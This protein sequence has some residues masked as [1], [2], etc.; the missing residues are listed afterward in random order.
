MASV[1]EKLTEAIQLGKAEQVRAILEEAD[2][3]SLRSATGESPLHDAVRLGAKPAVFKLLLETT[4]ISA[5][6]INGHT[7]TDLVFSDEQLDPDYET[8]VVNHTKAWILQGRVKELEKLLLSGWLFWPVTVEQAKNVSTELADFISRIPEFQEKVGQLHK[9]IQDENI[10]EVQQILDRKKYILAADRTGLPPFHKA[11]LHGNGEMVEWFCEEFKFAIEHKDSMGRTVLHYA[12]GLPDAGYIYSM[13][14]NAGANEDA[15][16]LA[17][18]TPRDYYDNTELLAVMKIRQ[19]I[20]EILTTTIPEP[21][22]AVSGSHQMYIS[23]GLK[24]KRVP[25]PTTV[26]GRYVAEHLGTALTLALAEIAECRP[27]DPIEYLGQWLYKYRENR[28]HIDQQEKLMAE[29]REEEKQKAVEEKE[30][31]KIKEEQVAIMEA[32]RRERE[33]AEEERRR[34]EKEELQRQAR[35]M[36]ALAQR[37]NLDTVTEESE[38]ETSGKDKQGQS[39]LHKLAAQEGADL[40]ALLNLGYNLAERDITCKTPRDIAVEKGIQDNIDAIDNYLRGLIEKEKFS[41]LEQLLLDGYTEFQPVI[42]KL[43]SEGQTEEIKNFL[44]SI[45]EVQ[46]KIS[47]MLLAA[48]QGSLSAVQEQ[49]DKKLSIVKD[50]KGQSPLHKAVMM[51]H[52]EV[53]EHI[54]TAY[55]DT[56]KCKDQL[57]RTPYHYAMGLS[58]S[59]IQT[60]LLSKGADENAKDV[61]QRVPSYY[62]ENPADILALPNESSASTSDPVN[63]SEQARTEGGEDKE[64]EHA[65]TTQEEKKE[66]DNGTEQTVEQTAEQKDITE[67]P[68]TTT[69]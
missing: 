38:E 25:P 68:V 26:D 16:D 45:P 51:Q 7:V 20:E 18:R 56:L 47:S 33:K 60:L 24:T 1:R 69:S 5:R 54:V 8:M 22:L 43:S 64:E 46:S 17:G 4:D 58:N 34:K 36:D 31:E 49:L 3:T 63:S 21:K 41:L 42:D 32:E 29:I 62:K 35:E 2:A 11:V 59:D 40:T 12:A 44:Q 67:N 13:L 27:W 6:D 23:T 9:A 55:P 53:T 61:Y 14:N 28:N 37:P 65:A 48:Q 52:R 50:N 39:E 30:R 19:R 10:R 57:N 15:M 66:A